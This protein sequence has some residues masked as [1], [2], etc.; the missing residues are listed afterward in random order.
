MRRTVNDL[1]PLTLYCGLIFWLSGRS[2]T[3]DPF[4]FPHQDKLIHIA[5]Y[6]AMGWLACRFFRHLVSQRRVLILVS[7]AFC[8][9]YGITDEFHQSLVPGRTPDVMDWLADTL[10]AAI[11]IFL[12]TVYKHD[13]NRQL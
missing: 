6:A 9:L 2:G 3:P 5:L 8:S 10:G 12:I 11:A 7:I 1:T 4:L 13:F